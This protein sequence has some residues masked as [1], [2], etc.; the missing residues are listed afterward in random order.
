MKSKKEKRF[1]RISREGSGFDGQK[2]ILVDRETGVHYLLI[3]SGYGIAVTPL[4]GS[5]GAP[6][7]H[8][9]F[10]YDDE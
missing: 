6:I 4:L 3:H 1:V 2:D 5:D 9:S 7:V 10:D 8:K